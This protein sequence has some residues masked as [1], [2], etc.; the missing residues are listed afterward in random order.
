[1][2]SDVEA[3]LKRKN[4]ILFSRESQ[5]LQGLIE[6]MQ[7]QKHRSIMVSAGQEPAWNFVNLGQRVKSKCL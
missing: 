6:L 7:L 5:C 2:F 3:K 4:K 1:M